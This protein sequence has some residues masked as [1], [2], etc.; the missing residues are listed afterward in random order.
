M[1]KEKIVWCLRM[2]KKIFNNKK[3]MDTLFKLIWMVFLLLGILA[4]LGVFTGILNGQVFDLSQLL[5]LSNR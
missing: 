3:G 1:L 5:R 2:V 4:L